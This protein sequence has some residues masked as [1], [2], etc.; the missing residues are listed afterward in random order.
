MSR[1]AVAG[2]ADVAGALYASG[3]EV[4]RFALRRATLDDVFA[5]LTGAAR[6][7]GGTAD[8]DPCRPLVWL[9]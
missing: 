4:T 8:G 2:G 6:K 7:G 5:Q 1:I 9:G 3:V